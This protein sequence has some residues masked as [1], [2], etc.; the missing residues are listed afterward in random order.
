LINQFPINQNLTNEV[1]QDISFENREDNE[2]QN[3]ESITPLQY[4][5]YSANSHVTT[6][7]KV[8]EAFPRTLKLYHA[9]ILPERRL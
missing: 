2:I 3:E 7:S 8:K 1:I 6:P 9:P 4:R 5:L